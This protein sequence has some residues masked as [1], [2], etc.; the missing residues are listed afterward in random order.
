MTYEVTKTNRGF[1]T[2]EGITD[3]KG[4]SLRIQESSLVPDE[5]EG[6]FLWIG[7]N[8]VSQKQLS[9]LLPFL[10]EFAQTGSLQGNGGAFTWNDPVNLPQIQRF[11]RL[12]QE[13]RKF[14]FE[15]FGT[16][17]PVGSLKHLAE[18]ALEAAEAPDDPVEYADCQFLLWDAFNR[19]RAFGVDTFLDAAEA[20]LQVLKTRK[21][22]EPKDGEPRNHIQ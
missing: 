21:W 2:I 9:E 4:L 18:E 20:K 1:E 17:G 6:L 5:E 19:Q 16:V 10:M 3:S 7:D 11:T 8:H 13:H 12:Q 15:T 22:P 14:S